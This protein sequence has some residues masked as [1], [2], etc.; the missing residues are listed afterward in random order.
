[1][2][3]AVLGYKWKECTITPHTE[4]GKGEKKGFDLT[5]SIMW[6][7]YFEDIL[8][9]AVTAS[10]TVTNVYGLVSQLPIRGGERVDMVLN[11]PFGSVNSD[12]TFEVTM[13]VYKVTGVEAEGTKETFILHLISLEHFSNE[14]TRCMKKYF[15]K[16]KISDHV[17]DII[18]GVLYGG[19]KENRKEAHIEP[20]SN[21]YGFIGCSRKPFHAIT[22]LGAKGIS[23]IAKK[24]GVSG[25]GKEG[26]N[27]G[28]SGYL[29][30]E[31][32]AGYHFKSIDSIVA[33]VE[34]G[35]RK[36]KKVKFK[37]FYKGKIIDAATLTNDLK[38]INFE[39]EKNIDFRKALSVG[40]YAN[41]T[42]IYNS[43]TNKLHRFEYA[44]QE[45]TKHP[46]AKL[47]KQN[48]YFVKSE[49]AKT[50]TRVFYRMTDHGVLATD[51]TLPDSG[52]DEGDIAKSFS[53]YN[54]LFTQALN[55]LVPCNTK[56]CV[57]DVIHCEFPKTEG[58]ETTEPD[59]EVSGNYVIREVRHHFSSNQNT[60]SL[61]L[62]RDS[63]GLY[64]PDE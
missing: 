21:T 62:M 51:G 37:Y 43:V 14:S 15:P 56:L 27:K 35:S 33:G 61:K 11:S 12:D 25:G 23:T 50:P 8:Q 49:Y 40:M 46:G 34:I 1:M 24:S 55:I 42:Y 39:Y 54:I 45:E 59:D 63:Y 2:A 32:Q 26:E 6:M 60:S 41:D 7:D 9:P 53:R 16:V 64:G 57:G 20:T 38:I 31:T 10:I 48:K 36:L 22:W 18:D 19:N 5:N 3:S 4:D 58:G 52:R 44:L 28:T 29:F 17:K 30:F 13:Y 47:G